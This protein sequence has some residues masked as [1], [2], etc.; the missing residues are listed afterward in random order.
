[1]FFHVVGFVFRLPVIFL[2]TIHVSYYTRYVSI[3]S[4][5]PSGVYRHDT[6][7]PI[8]LSLFSRFSL[9]YYSIGVACLLTYSLLDSCVY[10]EGSACV[11]EMGSRYLSL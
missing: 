4:E 5:L 2:S 1:M 6:S 3:L 11:K 9:V 8:R 10:H 7:S